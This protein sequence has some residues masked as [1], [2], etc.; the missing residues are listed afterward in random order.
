[1][2]YFKIAVFKVATLYFFK[3]SGMAVLLDA[4]SL[5]MLHLLYHIAP[6]A[7]IRIPFSCY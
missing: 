4:L 3:V 2:S 5:E 6:L 7:S 1:M